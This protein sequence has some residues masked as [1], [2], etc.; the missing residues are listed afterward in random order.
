MSIRKAVPLSAAELAE[1]EHARSTGLLQAV[2]GQEAARSEA[3]ALHA[4][5]RLGLERLRERGA[6]VGYAALAA[7]QDEE[8]AAFHAALR[9]RRR[10]DTDG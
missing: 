3:A 4:L 7:A 10:G 9:G 6:E 2:A 5:L 8:D 1:I